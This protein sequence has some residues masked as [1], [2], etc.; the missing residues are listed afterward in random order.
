MDTITINRAPVPTLWA[1]V[2][3]ERLGFEHDESLPQVR[4]AM[5]K[6]S[7]ARS[8]ERLAEEAFRLYEQFRPGVPAGESDKAKG[9]PT[10]PATGLYRGARRQSA[11]HYSRGCDASAANPENCCRI[12]PSTTDANASSLCDASPLIR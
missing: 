12:T 1:V 4:T 2:V 6:L 3:A 7:M 10:G 9:V 11:L 8:P 5:T